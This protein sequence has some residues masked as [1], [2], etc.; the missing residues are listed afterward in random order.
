[1]KDNYIHIWQRNIEFDN[2]THTEIA[3]A[4]TRLSEQVGR[5]CKFEA[6]EITECQEQFD[7]KEGD[8]L[9]ARF[10][11][12]CNGYELPKPEL[13]KLLFDQIISDP[14]KEVDEKGQAKRPIVQLIRTLLTLAGRNHQPIRFE[15]W[16]ENQE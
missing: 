8:W 9:S 13:L 7:Q 10:K 11:R 5:S 1:T 15:R 12:K 3:E 2:F 4:M 16:K 6:S 14:A